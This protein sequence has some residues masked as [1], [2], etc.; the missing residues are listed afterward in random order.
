[1]NRAIH[2]V[3]IGAR[4][5]VGFSAEASAAAVRA[6]ISR[7]RE[8]PTLV[9]RRGSAAKLAFDGGL[10]ADL[11]GPLRLRELARLALAELV[12]KLPET[13][14]SARTEL[15][16]GLPEPRPGLPRAQLADMG[17][18]VA[19][20][21]TAAGLRMAV[22]ALPLGHAAALEAARLATGRLTA[23]EADLCVVGG[24]DT[25]VDP[26]TVR[27][28]GRN[29][30]L[31]DGEARSAFVPG[32]GA[33]FL[34]LVGDETRKRH[35]LLPL[36]TLLGV[37]AA[38]ESAVLGSEAIN[39]GRGLTDA[40]AG[41]VAGLSLPAEM[42]DETYGDL[43]G[44]RHRSEEWGFAALRLQH[45]IRDPTGCRKPVSEWGDVGAASGALFMLLAIQAFRRGYAR[46]PRA[47]CWASSDGGLRAATVL[48]KT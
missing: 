40:I 47:L 48:Q 17:G 23:R 42:I 45:A 44:E 33:A 1:V 18:Y 37:H 19:R 35:Q 29:G 24:A 15:Y 14:A 43:N 11:F 7:M 9:N 12:A 8:H 31:A 30:R 46:G 41:A 21:G 10:P 16:L 2:V 38:R 5:P 26:R 13:L 25:Y 4:T 3:A 6:G 27:W 34:A 36:A 20:A 32:E 39:L 22:H 28:L